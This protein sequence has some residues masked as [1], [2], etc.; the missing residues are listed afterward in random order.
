ML[1][2][3]LAVA[4]YAFFHTLTPG[5]SKT[6]LL[7]AA[8][9]GT[10]RSIML[11]FAAAFAAAHGLLMCL[12]VALGFL[13][14]SALLGLVEN[15]DWLVLNA[16]LYVLAIATG[17]FVY[18]V[19]R[20]RRAA[21][22]AEQEFEPGFLEKHPIASGL[23]LGCLPCPDSLGMGLIV[24]NLA[25]GAGSIAI[26]LAVVWLVVAAVIV[27]IAL[28]A[29]FLPVERLTRRL[30]FPLW[31]PAAGA[32]AVCVAVIVYRMV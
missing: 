4:S 10:R 32:A 11:R 28:A 1:V 16:S 23:G 9:A 2:E 14:K 30:S 5:H 20:Q 8:L 22:E 26:T 6:I 24:P 21:A 13:F 18:T 29:S 12:F 31:V 17:Y 15:V 25:G 3:L 7:A 19:Y 27:G